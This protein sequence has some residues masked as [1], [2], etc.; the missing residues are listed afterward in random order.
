M[1]WFN[2]PVLM[3]IGSCLVILKSSS[4]RRMIKTNW[5]ASFLS[6]TPLFF[7]SAVKQVSGMLEQFK[8]KSAQRKGL[9]L[10]RKPVLQKAK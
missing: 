1:P 10:K 6:S 9:Y 4:L 2:N 8:I 7:W 3:Q 5:S